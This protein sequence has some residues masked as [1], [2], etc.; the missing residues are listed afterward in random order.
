MILPDLLKE[1]E[2]SKPLLVQI[3][4]QKQIIFWLCILCEIHGLPIRMSG[5]DKLMYDQIKLIINYDEMM[6]DMN[7]QK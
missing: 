5:Q 6:K 2:A 3:E 4:S 1:I 7:N